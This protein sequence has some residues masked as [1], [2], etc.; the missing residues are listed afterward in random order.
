MRI[1]ST[2]VQ[3]SLNLI[4]LKTTKLSKQI[5]EGKMTLKKKKA[6]PKKT[7]SIYNSTGIFNYH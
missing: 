6:F 2:E 1:N 5:G 4:F 3:P 7:K